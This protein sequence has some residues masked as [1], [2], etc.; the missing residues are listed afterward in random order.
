MATRVAFILSGPRLDPDE[1]TARLG[2]EPS[3]AYRV[4]ERVEGEARPRRQGAWVLTVDGPTAVD[5]PTLASR[6]AHDLLDRLAQTGRVLSSGVLARVR[7]S[8]ELPPLLTFSYDLDASIVARLAELGVWVELRFDDGAPRCDFSDGDLDVGLEVW[9][10]DRDPG[11]VTDRLGLSPSTLRRREERIDG[12]NTRTCKRSVWRLDLESPAA[13]SPAAAT[14]AREPLDER[15]LRLV[16]QLPVT[17]SAWAAVRCDHD[18]RLRC[19]LT[20]GSLSGS[21]LLEAETLAA[22]APLGI[23][24]GFYFYNHGA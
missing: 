5:A 4:G 6:L 18:V 14:T 2:L 1:V 12:S 3:R 21:L 10:G 15:L 19:S 17:S 8:F 13:E 24:I 20:V 9:T 7:F 22:V 16:A 23:P 11:E